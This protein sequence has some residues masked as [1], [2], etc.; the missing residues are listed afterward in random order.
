MRRSLGRALGVL[1][2]LVP[3]VG[4]AEV[5]INELHYDNADADVGEAVEVVATAGED[6]S[7]YSLYFYNGS[8]GGLSTA[9]SPNP[10]AIGAGATVSCGADVRIAVVTPNQIENGAQDGIAPVAPRGAVVQFLS[11]EGTLVANAGPASGMGSTDIGV[12]ESGGTPVGSSLQL[13]GNG[14]VP[15]DFSWQEAAAAT[16]GGCNTGQTF[17]TPVDNPPEV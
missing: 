11:Y 16:F 10:Q 1:G 5:F 17:G 3:V 13:A 4:S 15:A 7:Q 12:M 14:T 6:L 8:T 2:L 9:T